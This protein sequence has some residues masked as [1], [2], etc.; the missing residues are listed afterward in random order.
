MVSHGGVDPGYRAQMLRFP[1]RR[2]TICVLANNPYYD[3]EGLARHVADVYLGSESD[4]ITS[5]GVPAP[6]ALNADFLGKYLD[7][8][9]GRVRELADQN[10][11]LT[12]RSGG[13][14]YRLNIAAPSHFIE[15]SNDSKIVFITNADSKVEMTL[16]A[17]G[18]APSR[19]VKIVETGR[20]TDVG[21]YVGEYSSAELRT[22]WGIVLSGDGLAISS[23]DNAGTLV[24]LD[25]DEFSWQGMLIHFLRD[26]GGTVG[27]F[28]LTNVRDTNF[29]FE[30]KR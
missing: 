5:L 6:A 15:P 30:R 1:E 26:P 24:P 18:G 16:A 23:T 3:V 10:G 25:K 4:K 22:E 11:V 21:D 7:R 28:T 14:S 13:Q 17:P 8:T 27:G 12:L 9:T 2:L 29:V 19:S 20:R